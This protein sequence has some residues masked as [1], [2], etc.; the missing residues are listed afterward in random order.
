MSYS[1]PVYGNFPNSNSSNFQTKQKSGTIPLNDPNTQVV[2]YPSQAPIPA[3]TQYF[4]NPMIPQVVAPSYGIPF[5]QGKP[6]SVIQPE[7]MMVPTP[8]TDPYMI[9]PGSIPDS[10]RI[11]LF[12]PIA[13]QIPNYPQIS[14]VPQQLTPV[15]SPS[16]RRKKD[17][18]T[19]SQSKHQHL[20]TPQVYPFQYQN[21]SYPQIGSMIQVSN[22]PSVMTI[23]P[24][25]SAVNSYPLISSGIPQIPIQAQPIQNSPIPAASLQPSVL[26]SAPLSPH[27]LPSTGVQPIP[28]N[29][30]QMQN[31]SLKPLPQKSA[32]VD[33]NISKSLNTSQF[34]EPP[35]LFNI[36]ARG[37]L[38][39]IVFEY[40]FTL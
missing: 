34:N 21:P 37:N 33:Q 15:P 40:D 3:Q 19:L 22:M 39:G 35:G 17:I 20:G 38:P 32:S 8:I 16:K 14:N 11:Q 18:H 10:S 5:Y 6:V 1:Q 9:Q 31:P 7:L 12:S 36:I 30:I 2:L 26:P 4:Q 27:S 24:Q 25:P 13:S 28:V 23:P 29:S